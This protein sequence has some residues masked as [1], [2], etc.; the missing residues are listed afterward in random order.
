ME[1]K[2]QEICN[3]LCDLLRVTRTGSDIISIIYSTDEYEDEWVTVHWK[4]RYQQ[5]ICITADS[6]IALIHDILERI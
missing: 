5:K 4:G 6:G 2:K 1:E 3:K